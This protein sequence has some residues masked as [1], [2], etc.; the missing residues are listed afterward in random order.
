LV[1][2]GLDLDGNSVVRGG[3]GTVFAVRL[4]ANNRGPRKFP[5]PGSVA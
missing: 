3:L 4:V 1:G 5:S 2:L